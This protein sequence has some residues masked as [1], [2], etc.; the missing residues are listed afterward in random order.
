[1]R[2]PDLDLD[3]VR[4]FVSVVEAGGFTQASKVLHLTQPAVTLKIKRLEDQLQQQLF[5]KTVPPLELSLEG[6]IVRLRLPVAQVEPRDGP[7]SEPN[8]R[9][10]LGV[11][12]H[13]GYH[14]LRVWLAGFKK[15]W[16]KIRCFSVLTPFD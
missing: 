6:E 11:I 1:M 13:F 16:P 15:A 3:L 5:R 7:F 2:L 9:I 12:A 14:Y 4:C 10:R 8:T